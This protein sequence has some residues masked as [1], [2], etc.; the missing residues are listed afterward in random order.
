MRRSP[1]IESMGV[2]VGV[3]EGVPSGEVGVPAGLFKVR[4]LYQFLGECAILCPDDAK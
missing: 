2:S 4:I 1:D 3:S